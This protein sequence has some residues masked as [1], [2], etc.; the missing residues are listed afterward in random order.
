MFSGYWKVQSDTAHAE[1][2]F[3][4]SAWIMSILELV[5]ACNEKRKMTK[6]RKT[7]RVPIPL[8]YTNVTEVQNC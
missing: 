8:K 7:P 5:T 6:R 1:K 2:P 4:V 3:R